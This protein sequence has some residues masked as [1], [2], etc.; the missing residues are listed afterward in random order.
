MSIATK[1][2]SHQD[3]FKYLQNCLDSICLP[4][5]QW[6]FLKGNESFFGFQKVELDYK[7]RKR[8]AVLSDERVVV[9]LDDNK[10]PFSKFIHIHST[11]EC[12]ELL[13]TVDM[14]EL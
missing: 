14:L 1:D 8:V 10:M 5:E 11:N 4:S 13:K 7:V 2:K 12:S 9:Y 3:S 6:S